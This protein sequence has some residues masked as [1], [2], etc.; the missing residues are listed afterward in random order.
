MKPAGHPW[1]DPGGRKPGRELVNPLYC[2]R[3]TEEKRTFSIM[4]LAQ[5][6][7]GCG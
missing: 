2:L 5:F 3:V 4:E 7:V 1:N 6:I